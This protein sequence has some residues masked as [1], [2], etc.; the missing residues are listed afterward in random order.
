[1]ALLSKDR[2]DTPADVEY[3]LSPAAGR[4]LKHLAAAAW[5]RTQQFFGKTIKLYA[6]LYLS[7]YCTNACPYCGFSKDNKFKE[8]IFLVKSQKWKKQS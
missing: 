4:G 1:M 6:P 2:L 8:N 7:N 3:L 5:Q